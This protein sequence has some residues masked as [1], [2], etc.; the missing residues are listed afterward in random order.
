MKAHMYG[1]WSASFS[2]SLLCSVVAGRASSLIF[3]LEKGLAFGNI[4]HKTVVVDF[5]HSSTGRCANTTL[6]IK[7]SPYYLY[8]TANVDPLQTEISI[9]LH[10]KRSITE[11]VFL[12]GENMIHA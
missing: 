11:F 4:P 3:M 7:L 12:I 9:R 5:A 2:V 6:T 1:L 10:F 8:E